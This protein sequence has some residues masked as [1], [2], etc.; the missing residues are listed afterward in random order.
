MIFKSKKKMYAWIRSN[1]E[2][3]IVSKSNVLTNMKTAGTRNC[4][5]CMQKGVHFFCSFHEKNP[6]NQLMNARMGST[7]NVHVRRG[8]YIRVFAVGPGGADQ[9]C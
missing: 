4:T 6:I 7:Q 8:S 3:S 9:Q 5:L 1:W 2:V